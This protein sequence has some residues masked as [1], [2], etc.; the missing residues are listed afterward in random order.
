MNKVVVLKRS[1]KASDVSD[2]CHQV[3]ARCAVHSGIS[4][5]SQDRTAVARYGF[6]PCTA[7]V[8]KAESTTPP[9]PNLGA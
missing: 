9:R 8:D 2:G 1:G 5:N 4:L 7:V 3:C 6:G